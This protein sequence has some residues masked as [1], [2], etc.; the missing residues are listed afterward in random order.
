ML[1]N[2]SQIGED[3]VG[4]V[5]DLVVAVSHDDVARGAQHEV[6]A[7]IPAHLRGCAMPLRTVELHHYAQVRPERVDS[8]A[9]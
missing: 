8:Y 9:A 1:E 3:G 7:M 4:L 5:C 6:A 2:G